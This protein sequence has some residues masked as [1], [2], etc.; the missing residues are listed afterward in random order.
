MKHSLA[1]LLCDTVHSVVV[2]CERTRLDQIP[3]AST[4]PTYYVASLMIYFSILSPQGS[5]V[6]VK[7]STAS[8]L[9]CLLDKNGK[10]T[11]LILLFFFIVPAPAFSSFWASYNFVQLLGSVT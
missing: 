1:F 8:C 4:I 2:L 7:Q 10:V 9:L 6:M 11:P 3:L 5:M